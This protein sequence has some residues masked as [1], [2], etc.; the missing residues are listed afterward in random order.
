[1]PPAHQRAEQA[2]EGNDVVLIHQASGVVLDISK[3]IV[4]K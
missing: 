2:K 3:D 4:T 1:M